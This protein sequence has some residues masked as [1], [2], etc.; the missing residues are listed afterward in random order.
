MQIV[1]T[2]ENKQQPLALTIGNFDGVHRG[3]QAIIST[4][5]KTA[6][7]KNLHPAV[8]TFS[9]HAKVL[10]KDC[11][12]YLISSD[13][14]KA[15]YLRTHG[16]KTLYQ[17]PFDQNF[18]NITAE[19]FIDILVQQLNVKHLLVGDDFRFGYQG[20]GDFHLLE[21]KVQPHNVTV[22]RTPTIHYADKRISSSRIREAVRLADF[23][24]VEKLLNRR[25][26]Y[27]GIVVADKQLGRTIDF[28]TAN[29]R[30]PD[31]R[32][33]PAGVF[34]VWVNIEDDKSTYQGM[35]NIGTK[36]TL[37]NSQQRQIETHIFNFSGDLYGKKLIVT[38]IEK[39]RDEQKFHGLTA[40]IE[41]LHNDKAQ[42]LKIF[43]D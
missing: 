37:E 22:E 4:L 16:V 11:S 29:L 30:F 24:L 36:P 7:Q 14:E 5:I 28:P 12:N 2:L 18:A 1:H 40:L 17:I 38:P 23:D 31:T 6:E 39:I 3:H 43:A 8:M 10:F 20:K 9:P 26:S 19:Q 13:E 35:C 25:L 27:Q 41:Q 42:A 32:L 34:A 15:D 33:L 21:E